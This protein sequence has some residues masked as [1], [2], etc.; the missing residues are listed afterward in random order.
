[1]GSFVGAVGGLLFIIGILGFFVLLVLGSTEWILSGGDKAKV[2][3]ARDRIVQGLIGLSILSLT[4]AIILLL[5]RFFGITIVGS[6]SLPRAF[7][8]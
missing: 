5:Q 3:I 4:L 6:I 7:P 8:P 1:V 2:Q